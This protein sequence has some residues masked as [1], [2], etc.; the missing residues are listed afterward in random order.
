YLLATPWSDPVEFTG[1]QTQTSLWK[2]MQDVIAE[3]YSRDP[4]KAVKEWLS[5]LDQFDRLDAQMKTMQDQIDEARAA[6]GPESS[7]AKSLE[8]R[9]ADA[10]KEHTE[11]LAREERVRD[12]GLL[13]MPKK[14]A[15]AGAAGGQK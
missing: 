4:A 5:L 1:Q 10:R 9:L 13:P 14:V 15:A 6:E 7:R 11:A 2:G 3:R 12:I 8:K